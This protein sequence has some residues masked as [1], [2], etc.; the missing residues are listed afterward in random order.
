[1]ATRDELHS[2]IDHMNEDE[3]LAAS[4]H[5]LSVL[6]RHSRPKADKAQSER[7]QQREMQFGA[8]AEQHWCEAL[9]RAAEAG[10]PF[11]VSGFGG[12]QFG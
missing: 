4:M 10:S 9:Q 8:A 11:N 6:S 3:L 5:L 7:L 1:M 12:R 2:I